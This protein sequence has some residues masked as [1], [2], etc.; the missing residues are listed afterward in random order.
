M[1]MFAVMNCY[2]GDPSQPLLFACQQ[3]AQARL[4]P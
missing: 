4:Q 3:N 2:T 1:K